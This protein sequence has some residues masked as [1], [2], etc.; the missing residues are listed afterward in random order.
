MI[1]LQSALL[2]Y[3]AVVVEP[4]VKLPVA[5]VKVVQVAELQ[6]L[7]VK[8]VEDGVGAG[9]G[10]GVGGTASDQ[11]A[12]KPFLGMLVSDSKWMSM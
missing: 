5:A 6:L 8:P 11:L 1:Q 10:A 7:H 3:E 9:V 12:A 4:S 2:E